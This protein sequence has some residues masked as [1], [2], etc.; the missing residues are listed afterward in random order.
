MCE[1]HTTQTSIINIRVHKTWNTY[2]LFYFL[3]WFFIHIQLSRLYTHLQK[4]TEKKKSVRTFYSQVGFNVLLY[5]VARIVRL[6]L[7]AKKYNI[8]TDYYDYSFLLLPHLLLPIIC[9]Y[10][11]FL[12]VS[13]FFS[14]GN[15]RKCV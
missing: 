2:T 15:C 1:P 3:P 5:P 11:S 10:T 14:S 8:P 13:L 4:Y 12:Y 9:L 7:F 6:V